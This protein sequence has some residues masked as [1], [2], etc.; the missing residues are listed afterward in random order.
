M[1][2]LL[3]NFSAPDYLD[4]FDSVASQRTLEMEIIKGIY[5][6]E[7]VMWMHQILIQTHRIIPGWVQHAELN[8]F[9]IRNMQ[10]FLTLLQSS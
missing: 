7:L 9:T 1:R 2:V 8:P 5:V 10:H 3:E 6:P 4:E